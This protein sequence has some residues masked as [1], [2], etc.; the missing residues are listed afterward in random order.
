MAPAI[1]ALW[2]ARRKLADA[3]AVQLTRYPDALAQAYRTLASRKMKVPGAVAVH[4]LFPVWDP[5]VDK[6]HRRPD[7][8]SLLMHMQLP[9]EPRLRRLQRLGA[10]P[11]GKRLKRPD[12]VY[13]WWDVAVGTGWIGVGAVLLCGVVALS[14]VGASATLYGLGWLLHK[15]LVSWWA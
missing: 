7:V 5:D 2:R 11:S 6:D 1:S 12:P 9:L 10:G 3:T 8:T 15:V 13:T 14:V 4:F